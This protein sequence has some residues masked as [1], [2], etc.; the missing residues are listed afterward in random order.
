MT[1]ETPRPHLH[2]D[3]NYIQRVKGLLHSHEELEVLH[4]EYLEDTLK[5]LGFEINLEES[6]TGETVGDVIPKII[7]QAF[8]H[9][10]THPP[11]KEVLEKI[12][13]LWDYLAENDTL[14]NADLIYV[15]GGIGEAAVKEALK[16][17]NEGYA[18]KILFSGKKAS[19][20]ADVEITEAEK[21]A[22]IA[23]EAGISKEDILIENESVNTPENIVNSAKLLHSLN[24]L[25]KK[26]IAVS[27][28]YHMKRA[29]LSDQGLIGILD[30]FDILVPPLNTLETLI[31]KTRMDG[32]ISVLS[33]LNCILHV[34]QNTFNFEI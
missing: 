18:P 21:Y 19:Y 9:I 12:L 15:F 4:F 30:L 23:I 3:S 20:M 8:E 6:Y 5:S 16:L 22:E 24:F 10:T 33:T 17:K 14:E 25:P 28:P 11:N 1:Q 2:S 13:Q 27:L 34:G 26:V 7:D 32:H 31:L 29:G